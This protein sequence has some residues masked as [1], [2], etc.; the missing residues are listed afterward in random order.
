MWQI[1]LLKRPE[2]NT[3]QFLLC[4]VISGFWYNKTIVQRE[5]RFGVQAQGR[6]RHIAWAWYRTMN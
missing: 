2:R 3:L 5:Q 1:N 4:Q 6:V